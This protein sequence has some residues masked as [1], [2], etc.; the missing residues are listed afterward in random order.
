MIA[1]FP[2]E[3]SQERLAEL[4]RKVGLITRFGSTVDLVKAVD[5]GTATV[6]DPSLVKIFR[7]S[8]VPIRHPP[9]SWTGPW[10]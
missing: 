7:A 3:S 6:A 2:D 4:E 10:I 9:R 1:T 5:L 8:P